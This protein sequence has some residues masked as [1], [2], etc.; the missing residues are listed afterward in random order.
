[1]LRPPLPTPTP[2]PNWQ[3]CWQYYLY[4]NLMVRVCK[5]I[6]DRL[7]HIG[8]APFKTFLDQCIQCV[9]DI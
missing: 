6:K 1:M 7:G 9:R 8:A 3:G 2:P 5:P 4:N